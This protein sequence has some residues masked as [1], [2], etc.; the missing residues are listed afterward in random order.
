MSLQSLAGALG[1]GGPDPSDLYGAGGGDPDAQA[2]A[3]LQQAG[4]PDQ[5]V[6]YQT[7][8]EALDGAEDALQQFIQM[9]PDEG[10]RAVAAQ[11]MQNIIKLKA[12]NQ[13]AQGG[14][15]DMTSLARAL[16]PSTGG[17]GG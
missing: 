12:K 16:Q 14:G 1:Q 15:G 17:A 3:A 4:Q 13:K 11:C 7:S 10:D 5:D 9:D 8:L 2:D 6:Q